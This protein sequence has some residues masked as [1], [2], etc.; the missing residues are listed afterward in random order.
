VL[1]QLN[2]SAIIGEPGTGFEKRGN[3]GPFECG[4]CAFFDGACNQPDM[5]RMS[6]EPR[7]KDGRVKVKREDCCEYVK[8]VGDKWLRKYGR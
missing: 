3:S 7:E 4:N 1:A 6:K 2:A 8:R 5:M